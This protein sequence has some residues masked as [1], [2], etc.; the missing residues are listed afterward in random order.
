MGRVSLRTRRTIAFVL[1]PVM[2]W[3]SIAFLAALGWLIVL[4]VDVPRV[5]FAA[6][7][8][9]PELSKF[10]DE[11]YFDLP[12]TEW[13][14]TAQ[15]LGWRISL[16]LLLLWP[17]FII[18]SL[19]T[20]F[21][22][23]SQPLPKYWKLYR[24][25]ICLVPPLR[26]CPAHPDMN[27]RLWLPMLGWQRRGEKLRKL[28]E[29]QLSFPMIVAALLIL[30]VLVIEWTMTKQIATNDWL[31]FALHL[32]TG[33]IWF[34]F[35]TEFIVM[36][37]I[38]DRKVTY[39]KKHWIDLVII[40]LPLVSFLRTLRFL[41][42]TKLAKLANLERL[43]K[44]IRV[45]RMRGLSMRVFRAATVLE[46]LQRFAKHSPKKQK[47]LIT[48]EIRT[49]ESELK[50]LKRRLVEVEREIAKANT[51]DPVQQSNT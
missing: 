14:R 11:S 46:I 32:G 25:M 5:S 45:Y 2:F 1:G 13:D 12:M 4:W 48:L 17:I 30:P 43:T 40:V 38:T 3:L 47:E 10:Q 18:E 39:L 36:I 8:G 20:I 51:D 19:A 16:G 44:M 50:E 26:L 23:W 49:K 6:M 9:S 27:C 22:S 41:R 42:V 24:S 7:E 35:A 31:R 37:S 28:V 21:L 29:W 15:T 34:A 33:A